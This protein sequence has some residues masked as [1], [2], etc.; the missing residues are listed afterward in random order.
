M[1]RQGE[2]GPDE[3]AALEKLQRHVGLQSKAR[4][5]QNECINGGFPH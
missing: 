5:Y 4:L 3:M 2:F 1:G